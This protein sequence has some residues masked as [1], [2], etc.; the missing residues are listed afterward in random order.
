M[1]LVDDYGRPKFD[2]AEFE[3]ALRL[4]DIKM[5]ERDIEPII[6]YA[7]GGYVCLL[8]GK[9]NMTHDIDAFYNA[10]S[11]L[12][13]AIWEV[14]QETRNP[15]WLNNSIQKI[16]NSAA[17]SL[18][19]LLRFDDSFDM[20]GRFNRITVYAATGHV[21]IFMKLMAFR[22]DRSDKTDVQ[23]IADLAE[24]YDLDE[25]IRLVF[26]YRKIMRSPADIEYALSDMLYA[27]YL[28][29]KIN[30][31]QYVT[32]NHTVLTLVGQR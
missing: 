11:D 25:L 13:R 17:P 26:R 9:R 12:E 1:R 16:P 7:V 4:L 5:E 2:L 32:A 28:Q 14:G 15:E 29:G 22:M 30:D 18:D 20:V 31:E 6:L 21:V 23:D 27:M 24:D 19:D 3:H 8:K 10:G